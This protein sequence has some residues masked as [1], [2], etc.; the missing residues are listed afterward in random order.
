MPVNSPVGDY[1]AVVNSPAGM[2]SIALH[3]VEASPT[4]HATPSGISGMYSPIAM[5]FPQPIGPDGVLNLPSDGSSV[6][7]LLLASGLNPA[8]QLERKVIVT[9]LADSVETHFPIL[10]V[11][12][13]G[14]PHW[15]KHEFR[16]EFT[17]RG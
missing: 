7:V 11:R 13:P 14:G 3:V 2:R 15:S 4:I 6:F 17:A 8:A 10:G 9:R 16:Y 12:A 1:S 5:P